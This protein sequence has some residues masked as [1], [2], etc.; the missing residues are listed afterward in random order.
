MS[1]ADLIKKGSLRQFATVTVA[2]AATVKPQ[3]PSTVASVA[4]VSVATA[5]KQA[6]NESASAELPVQENLKKPQLAV[7]SDLANLALKNLPKP[8][9]PVA[10]NDPAQVPERVA[11][12]AVASLI[13]RETS[14]RKQLVRSEVRTETLFCSTA[15]VKLDLDRWC[16]PYSSAM[17]GREIDTFAERSSLFNRRGLPALDAERLAD[18]LVNRDR[19]GDDRHLCVECRHCRPDL[20]CVNKLA[21][22]HVLQR[23]DHFVPNHLS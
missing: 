22:L 1:F 2:T 19:D 16:W 6:T 17:T 7:V 20:R 8:A 9:L 23:C 18:K 12:D 21:V 3:T 11:G 15:A 5:Q 14:V 10:A 13:R 4:T